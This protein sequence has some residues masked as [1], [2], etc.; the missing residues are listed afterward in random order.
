MARIVLVHGAFGGPWYWEPVVG[1]PTRARAA[2]SAAATPAAAARV[3][4]EGAA[5]GE[6]DSHYR[7]P[8]AG[9]LPAP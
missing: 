2:T 6:A 8:G 3:A 7:L 5:A 4:A 9:I 1:P